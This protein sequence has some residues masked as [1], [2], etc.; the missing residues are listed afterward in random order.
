MYAGKA[1]TANLVN[2]ISKFQ[3]QE[4][5]KKQIGNSSSQSPVTTSAKVLGNT[6]KVPTPT[7]T[8]TSGS[9][10]VNS[11]RSSSPPAVVM[12]NNVSRAPRPKTF[13]GHPNEK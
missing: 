3:Q 6:N 9:T 4:A 11:A 5:A 13:Y 12:R 8:V 10:R 2:L 7:H 1:E